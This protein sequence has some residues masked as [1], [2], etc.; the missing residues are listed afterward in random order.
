MLKV[1]VV[2]SSVGVMTGHLEQTKHPLVA[3]AVAV[4]DALDR[5]AT[6][7]PVF[8]SVGEKEQ[9]LESL[10]TSRERLEGLLL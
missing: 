8:L 4:A 5:A 3:G 2:V 7:N 1:S 6:G 9:V 10:A